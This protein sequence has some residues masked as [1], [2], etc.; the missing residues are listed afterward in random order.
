MDGVVHADVV[1]G[2]LETPTSVVKPGA[3]VEAGS[4]EADLER[5]REGN[6]WMVLLPESNRCGRTGPWIQ[7]PNFC[8][9]TRLG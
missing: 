2:G 6:D 4:K 3:R 1:M 9:V 5:G 8:N 7:R